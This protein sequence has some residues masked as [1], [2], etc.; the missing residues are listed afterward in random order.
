MSASKKICCKFYTWSPNFGQIFE[1]IPYSRT[2]Q[3]RWIGS[4]AFL[5]S[6]RTNSAQTTDR[7]QKT[8]VQ[9]SSRNSQSKQTR[10]TSTR[11]VSLLH[12]FYLLYKRILELIFIYGH[13]LKLSFSG[14]TMQ[15][16]YPDAE[17]VR[18]AR[19]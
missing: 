8:T 4:D 17:D 18:K 1:N 13:N 16:I 6:S 10:Y 12:I 5:H 19:V 14:V 3:N 11:K 2:F 15:K 7:T 9:I